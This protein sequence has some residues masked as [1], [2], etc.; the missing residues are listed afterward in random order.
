MNENI[1]GPQG[2]ESTSTHEEEEKG[3]KRM[4]PTKKMSMKDKPNEV[5]WAHNLAKLKDFAVR[6]PDLGNWGH[7][8]KMT[9]GQIQEIIKDDNSPSDCIRHVGRWLTIT[10][11]RRFSKKEKK[12]AAEAGN[13]PAGTTPSE[14]QSPELS[15]QELLSRLS[16]NRPKAQP[17]GGSTQ[18]KPELPSFLSGDK[19]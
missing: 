7:V 18:S 13:A 12:L 10:Y 17:E 8:L 2:S 19:N 1:T 9:D 14:G 4:S 5:R 6:N 3:R 11:G 16:P 15:A